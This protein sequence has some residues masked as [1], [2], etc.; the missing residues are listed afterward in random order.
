MAIQKE[1]GDQARPKLTNENLASLK[2]RSEELFRVFDEELG[3][4]R[5]YREGRAR[6]PGLSILKIARIAE[7]ATRLNMIEVELL[8]AQY[9]KN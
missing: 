1:A 2:L 9:E 8:T 6:K 7:V 3:R 5:A 4:W